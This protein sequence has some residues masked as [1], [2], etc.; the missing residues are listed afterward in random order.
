MT[1]IGYMKNT[2]YHARLST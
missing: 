2:R 1:V